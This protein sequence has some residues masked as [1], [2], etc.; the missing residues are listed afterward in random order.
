MIAASATMRDTAKFSE[1][2][3]EEDRPQAQVVRNKPLIHLPKAAIHSPYNQYTAVPMKSR[4]KK[5]KKPVPDNLK[6][7][8]DKLLSTY[9][10]I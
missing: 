4:F 8:A 7:A 2:G 3:F 10:D 1:P 5:S 6:R 9:G